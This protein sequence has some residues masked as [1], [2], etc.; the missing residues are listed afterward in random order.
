[1]LDEIIRPS[2][3]KELHLDELHL[4]LPKNHVDD[5]TQQDGPRADGHRW[6]F[7]YCNPYK[8]LEING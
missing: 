3:V 8:W 2:L 1:M 6:S 7:I 5:M 4:N